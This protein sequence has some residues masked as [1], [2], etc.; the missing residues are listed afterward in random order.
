MKINKY[1]LLSLKVLLVVFILFV[2]AAGYF[3]YIT[4]IESDPWPKEGMCGGAVSIYVNDLKNSYKNLESIFVSKDWT[5]RYL[6]EDD[7]Y[8]TILTV[9]LPNSKTIEL[10]QILKE[11]SSDNVLYGAKSLFGLDK[12][13]LKDCKVFIADVTV[14]DVKALK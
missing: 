2:I 1:I 10:E 5:I 4:K 6:N 13:D 12:D 3:V 9:E 11:E 7:I 14:T 8:K